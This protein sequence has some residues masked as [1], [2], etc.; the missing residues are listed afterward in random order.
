MPVDGGTTRSRLNDACPQRRNSKRSA[1]RRDVVARDG[2]AV[3]VA[4]EVLQQH[5]DRARQPRELAQARFLDAGQ[6]V[7]AMRLP[8]DVQRAR[9]RRSRHHPSSI[10]RSRENRQ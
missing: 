2:D 7:D 3:L 9:T 5:A 10:S 6:T 1:L 4:Q 8:T